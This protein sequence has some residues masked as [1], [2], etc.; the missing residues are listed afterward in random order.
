MQTIGSADPSPKPLEKLI[1]LAIPAAL[2]YGGIMLFNAFAPT[3]IE[4]FNNFWHIVWV[5]AP[6]V[7]LSLYVLQNPTFLWMGYKTLCRKITSFFIKLDPL[8]FMDRYVDLLKEKRKGLQLS[9]TNLKAKKI[10][11]ERECERL[12]GEITDDLKMAKAAQATGD[13]QLASHKS[14]LAA[15]LTGSYNLYVPILQKM[16]TNLKFLDELDENWGF[17]IEK[18]SL[19]VEAKRKEFNMLK[20]MA[21]ALGAAEEFAKGDTE[22]NRIYKESV[23]ALEE[24]VTKKLAYIEEFEN[25]SKGVMKSMN[26][27]KQMM[28]DE[29]LDLLSRYEQNGSVFLDQDYSKFEIKIDP[30]TDLFSKSNA[31]AA[32]TN[33]S[34]NQKTTAT[35]GE[36]GDFLKK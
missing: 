36:F 19:T 1:R 18:L 12:K 28:S 33:F 21:K 24:N 2:I 9:K 8:S 13:R 26:L 11:L 22:A 15:T 14:S 25:N 32:K 10:E 4:F 29:G 34:S 27:E 31:N 3:L 35:N 16:E 7:F 17:S 20:T 23:Q 30:S 6:A 5:G